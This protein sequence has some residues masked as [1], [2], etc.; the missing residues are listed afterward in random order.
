MHLEQPK[1]RALCAERHVRLLCGEA[2][3]I[4][5]KTS[6]EERHLV[7]VLHEMFF[8][9]SDAADYDTATAFVHCPPIL[10]ASIHHPLPLS[11]AISPAYHPH[12]ATSLIHLKH[13]ESMIARSRSLHFLAQRHKHRISCLIPAIADH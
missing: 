8:I 11:A 12:S 7:L 5:T 6:I 10:L 13:D 9:Y 1:V 2:A 4:L 3:G